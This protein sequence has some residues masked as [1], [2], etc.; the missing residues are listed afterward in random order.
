MKNKINHKAFFSF[1]FPRI[2][3]CFDV[4]LNNCLALDCFVELRHVLQVHLL[5]PINSRSFLSSC[6]LNSMRSQYTKG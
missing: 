3:S 4:P 5:G 1:V 6:V 2:F